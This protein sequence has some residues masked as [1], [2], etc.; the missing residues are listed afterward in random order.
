MQHDDI[1]RVLRNASGIP[2]PKGLEGA[3]DE[4]AVLQVLQASDLATDVAWVQAALER[5]RW[6]ADVLRR[7][8]S[9]PLTTAPNPIQVL[10]ALVEMGIETGYLGVLM[11]HSLDGST[12]DDADRE[13]LE[14]IVGKITEESAR[15]YS[16]TCALVDVLATASEQEAKDESDAH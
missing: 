2:W 7:F 12:F 8:D 11:Q 10:G 15:I 14:G 3:T 1:C 6:I 13:L 16:H 4:R 9:E 5:E